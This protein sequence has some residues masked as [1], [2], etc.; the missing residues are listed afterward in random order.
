M[1]LHLGLSSIEYL[2]IKYKYLGHNYQLQLDEKI[3]YK[4]VFRTCFF[5]FVVESS[6]PL[7]VC[8]FIP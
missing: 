7:P 8:F 3:P 5:K 1:C 2:L 6:Q 4:S